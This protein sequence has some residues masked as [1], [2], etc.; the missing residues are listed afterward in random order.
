MNSASIPP[1]PALHSEP[2]AFFASLY[3]VRKSVATSRAQSTFVRCSRTVASRQP[4]C[5]SQNMNT[6]AVPSRSYS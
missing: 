6:F 2:K 1:R 3:F 5:G 4:A